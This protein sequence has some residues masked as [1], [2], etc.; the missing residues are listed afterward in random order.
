MPEQTQE[1][2]QSFFEA[3]GSKPEQAASMAQQS[4]NV[5]GGF[6]SNQGF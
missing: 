4:A 2:L 1:S 6:G 5:G 3:T